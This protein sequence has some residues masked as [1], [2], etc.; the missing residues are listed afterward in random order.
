M[1]KCTKLK[2]RINTPFMSWRKGQEVNV[3]ARDGLPVSKFWRDRLK[4]S[5]IDGC[6][7][8][9]EPAKKTSSK[10]SNREMN[11]DNAI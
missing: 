11:D 6:V 2:I 8:I 9:V 7:S 3:D 5:K 10:K 1:C 4:D